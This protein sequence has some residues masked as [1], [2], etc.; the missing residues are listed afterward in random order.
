[1]K[2]TKR[3]ISAVLAT[4]LCLMPMRAGAARAAQ[5]QSGG[6]ENGNGLDLNKIGSY[7]SGISNPDGGVAEIVSYDARANK[8]WA[9]NGATGML[10]ILDLNSM[11]GGVISAESLD[12]KALTARMMPEFTYGVLVQSPPNGLRNRS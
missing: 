11:E 5:V 10:D 9:V 3:V 8:A 4:A 2:H 6:Y 12:I 7:V 1:M